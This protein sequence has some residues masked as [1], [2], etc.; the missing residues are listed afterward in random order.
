[1][2]T[3]CCRVSLVV[4]RSAVICQCWAAWC[5][6]S[7][8]GLHDTR[9]LVSKARPT[10]DLHSPSPSRWEY[11][12]P[13]FDVGLFLSASII[14][15]TSRLSSILPMWP[16]RLSYLS[17]IQLV[18]WSPNLHSLLLPVYTCLVFSCYT[19]FQTSTARQCFSCAKC[20]RVTRVHQSVHSAHTSPCW[21]PVITVP[22]C[23]KPSHR[24]IWPSYPFLNPFVAIV[25]QC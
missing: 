16:R 2:T 11:G 5:C 9:W 12:A 19:S 13:F 6:Q 25:V 8:Q 20:P 14:P 24:T 23:L 15:N 17:T 18:C 1:M 4:C 10:I 21:W 3:V 7:I 22:Y